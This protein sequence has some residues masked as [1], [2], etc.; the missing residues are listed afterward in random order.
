[1]IYWLA[2]GALAGTG[3]LL[4]GLLLGYLTAKSNPV[5][6]STILVG[7]AALSLILPVLAYV[8]KKYQLQVEVPVSASVAPQVSAS[9]V[10]DWQTPALLCWAAGTLFLLVKFSVGLLRARALVARSK[11]VLDQRVWEASRGLRRRKAA[12]LESGEITSPVVIGFLRPSIL[13]PIGL[14]QRLDDVELRAVL[15]H[16]FS[17]VAHGHTRIG[18]LMALVKALYWP[19]PL[20]HILARQ[21][22]RAFEEAADAETL[23]QVSSRDFS[24]ALLNLATGHHLKSPELGLSILSHKAGL[25]ERLKLL[26][27]PAR[28]ATMKK[29]T[30]RLVGSLSALAIASI[31]TAAVKVAGD[32]QGQTPP[33]VNV[34]K[35]MP[36]SLEKT[37]EAVAARQSVR[38]N[39]IVE[40]P[41]EPAEEQEP[42]DPSG[43]IIEVPTE[44]DVVLVETGPVPVE[45]EIVEVAGAPATAPVPEEFSGVIT[46]VPTPV[47]VEGTQVAKPAPTPPVAPA[48]A[49][50]A[51]APAAPTPVVK[52]RA[53]QGRLAPTPKARVSGSKPVPKVAPLPRKVEGNVVTPVPPKAVAPE[54]TEP[55]NTITPVIPE[56]Q[57]PL[58]K[59]VPLLG[60]ALPEKV[61]GIPLMSGIPLLGER[62]QEPLVKP[63]LKASS[64]VKIPILSGIPIIGFLFERKP[65]PAG[66]SKEEAPRPKAAP[67]P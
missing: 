5:L 46:E 65:E 35:A 21:V 6:R 2:F 57:V 66:S 25:E 50:R 27:D 24:R 53:V 43:V 49:S 20:I 26:S 61:K 10:L 17:H 56:E 38:E 39:I 47:I 63:Q 62:V 44:P 14:I 31:L 42:S 55:E 51:K 8:L 58:L 11:G 37:G 28:T 9:V 48:S 30:F 33:D 13:F 1:V 41:G 67:S 3:V 12:I 59:G 40:V 45:N 15:A 16:E 29:H 54:P 7:S 60:E 36:S 18:L 34:V 22:F 52:A 4:T 64:K 19:N 32:T 23:E